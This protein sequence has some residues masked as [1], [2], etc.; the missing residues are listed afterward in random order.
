MRSFGDSRGRSRDDSAFVAAHHPRV[1]LSED[2][3][4]SDAQR[5]AKF[6][7][8]IYFLVASV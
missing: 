5:H 2:S 7:Q 3:R 1:L 8:L 4:E 6:M